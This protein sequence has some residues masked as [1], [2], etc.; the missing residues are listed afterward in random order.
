VVDD[1]EPWRIFARKILDRNPSFRLVGEA[2]D[3]IE[4]IEQVV[5][6]RPDLVL[7]DIGM[8]R[9]NGIGAAKKIK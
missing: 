7:L 8:P 4:A 1:S 9:L 2:R 3:G 5:T 6:L